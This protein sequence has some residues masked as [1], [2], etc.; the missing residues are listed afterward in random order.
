MSSKYGV[1]L[2]RDSYHGWPLRVGSFGERGKLE[3]LTAATDAV[4]VWSGGTT[5]VTLVTRSAG[6]ARRHRFERRS[7]MIDVLPR[8]VVIDE[9]SW[10]GQPSECVSVAFDEAGIA[11]LFGHDVRLPPEALRTALTDAHVVDLVQRLRAQA[12]SGPSWG[13]LYAEALSSTL[14][15]Y[16]YGRYS[17][18]GSP[19][20]ERFLPALRSEQLLSF[21]EE[22]LGDDLRLS[23]LAALVGYSPDHFA[24]LFKRAFG[25]SPYQYVIERRIERAKALLADSRLSIAAVAARCGF[26]SQAHLHTAFKARTGVT[27][28]AY[29]RR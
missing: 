7:G 13:P 24:R 14:A 26:A 9:V 19:D 6:G 2:R 22:H 12:V 11:R 18:V 10:R 20:G 4:L 27:P 8:G 17:F 5:E 1:P 25:K 16:V 15:S 29:R 23:E 28:G 3:S 21:V